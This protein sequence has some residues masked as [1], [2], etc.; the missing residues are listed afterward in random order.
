[1]NFKKRKKEKKLNKYFRKTID[2]K[3]SI[4]KG[5]NHRRI[6]LPSEN[7]TYG[8]RNRT[9][10]PIKNI[11]GYDYARHAEHQIRKEYNDIMIEVY[12]IIYL[13]LLFSLF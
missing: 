12:F 10:T 11:I 6:F 3:K 5:N 4:P 7:F 1:L 13:T 9:P 2:I 8:K